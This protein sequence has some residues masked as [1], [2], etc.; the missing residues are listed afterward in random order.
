[1]GRHAHR[2]HHKHSDEE[3]D[4]HSPLVAFLWGHLGWLVVKNRETH[5]LASYRKFAPDILKDPFYMKLEKSYAWVW[6]YILSLI[7]I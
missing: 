2:I 4:P 5:S 1:M 7:H 6:I 3:K